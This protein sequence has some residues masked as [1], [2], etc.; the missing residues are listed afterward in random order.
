[1]RKIFQRFRRS[2]GGA[3]ATEYA[4]LLLLI[5]VVSIP[6]VT[7]LGTEVEVVYDEVSTGAMTEARAE[8]IV[9]GHEDELHAIEFLDV[10]DADLITPYGSNYAV[11][12][13]GP[14][15]IRLFGGNGTQ[16]LMRNGEI[17]YAASAVY[18][19]GDLLSIY[20]ESP[21]EP[22]ATASVTIDILGASPVDT[23]SIT[24]AADLDP[25]PFTFNNVDD[26][27]PGDAVISNTVALEEF[28]GTKTVSVVGADGAELVV[29]GVNTGLPSAEVTAGQTLAIVVPA[30][31]EYGTTKIGTVVLGNYTTT[32]AVKTGFNLS[33][34]VI[35]SDVNNYNLSQDLIDNYGWDGVTPVNVGVTVLSGVTVGSTTTGLA[36][37]DTGSFPSGSTVMISNNGTIVGRGGNSDSNGGVA[38]R[39]TL[40][41]EIINASYIVGGGGGGG[42]GTSSRSVSGYWE[43]D[44]D[45]GPYWVQVVTPHRGGN[46]GV[47]GTAIVLGA[48]A[49]ISNSGI[50]G[51]GGGGGAGSNNEQAYYQTYDDPGGS[52]GGGA[53]YGYPGTR[54]GQSG[55]QGTLTTGGAGGRNESGDG[56]GWGGYAGRGG[57]LGASGSYSNGSWSGTPGAGGKALLSNGHDVTWVAGNDASQVK[58][59]VN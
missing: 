39:T 59:A 13:I 54:A 22:E 29:D 26:A 32:W 45:E 14:L 18:Q 5:A 41:A 25:A 28:S 51:G 19:A 37:F 11:I 30:S 56:G 53:G 17:L 15:N 20:M 58:G 46:G 1:M 4:L 36:A 27:A 38:L 50:I 42:F 24:T 10:N 40:P 43:N 7:N 23:W 3:A 34:I 8:A 33:D 16:S 6:V 9:A 12:N 48:G 21:E 47:G 49:E 35:A 44:P 57:D 31:D 2:V 52:G 55:A